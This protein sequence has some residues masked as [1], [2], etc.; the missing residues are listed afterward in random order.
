MEQSDQALNPW[1]SMWTKPRATIQHIIDTNP[2]QSVMLLAAI[3]GFSQAL[4]RASVR[5]LGNSFDWPYILLI[6]AVLGPI[7]GIIYLYL[8]SAIMRWV[9]GWMGGT[10]SPQA[11]RAALAWSCIPMIW[12]LIL[13]LPELALFGQEMFTTATPTLDS[14][15]S[16]SSVLLALSTIEMLIGIWA[17]VLLVLSLAQVQGFSAWKALGNVLLAVLVVMVPLLVMVVGFYSVRQ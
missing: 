13:W 5:D 16:L 6:A 12:A 2:E 7:S 4:D 14:T 15:P 3:Y 17:V 1:I 10:A 9:G 8:G 11:V